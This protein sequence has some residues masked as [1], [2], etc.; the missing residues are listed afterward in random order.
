MTGTGAAATAI[1]GNKWRHRM[2]T[3]ALGE[4]GADASLSLDSESDTSYEA[5]SPVSA[6]ASSDSA[7]AD[8]SVS[9]VAADAESDYSS[10]DSASERIE[11]E[12]THSLKEAFR[13]GIG[14][15]RRFG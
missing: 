9:L 2:N 5:D 10:S 3:S 11:V 4:K 15:F 1:N 13:P 6:Y 7:L 14:L 12:Q 8:T